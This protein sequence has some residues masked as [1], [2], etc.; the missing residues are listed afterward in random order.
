MI[1]ILDLKDNFSLIF[2]LDFFIGFLKNGI[3]N[4]VAVHIL[5]ALNIH[6][7]IDMKTCR[8]QTS[9]NQKPNFKE[10]F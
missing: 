3:N 4:A 7:L 1:L 10:L 5:N 6:Y 9:D 2:L 8:K